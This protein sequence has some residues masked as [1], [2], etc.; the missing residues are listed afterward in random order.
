[1]QISEAIEELAKELKCP[2]FRADFLIEDRNNYE[3]C[4]TLI[5]GLSGYL[6]K[7]N[8]IIYVEFE[9]ELNLCLNLR[10]VNPSFF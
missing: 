6:K 7:A 10:G 4:F 3:V 2:V 1:M 8:G 9:E 5:N